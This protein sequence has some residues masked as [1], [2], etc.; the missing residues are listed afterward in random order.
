MSP[1]FWPKVPKSWIGR[2][3]SQLTKSR[4]R[5]RDLRTLPV[6]VEVDASGKVLMEEHVK[7]EQGGRPAP[8]IHFFDDTGGAS[9]KVHIG[10]FG[11]HLDSPA[12]S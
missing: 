7:I 2:H 10:W 6:A 5:F 1:A 9:G 11:D 8:R 12:K 3:E 4:A